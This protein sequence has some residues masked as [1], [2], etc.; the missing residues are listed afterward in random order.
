VA[1]GITKLLALPQAERDELRVAVSE[2]VHREW[3]WDR[4]AELLLDL[5]R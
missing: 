3:N 1:E 4:T 2:F 5:A